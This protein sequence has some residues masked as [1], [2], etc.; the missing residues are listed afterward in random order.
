MAM[1]G[2]LAELTLLGP[3]HAE[4]DDRLGLGAC[5]IDIDF[6]SKRATPWNLIEGERQVTIITS[7]TSYTTRTARVPCVRGSS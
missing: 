5:H 6:L 3:E 4:E 2:I 7:K 1:V